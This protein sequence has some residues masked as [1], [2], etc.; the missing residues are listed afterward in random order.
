ML[1]LPVLLP[2][3]AFPDPLNVRHCVGVNCCRLPRTFMDSFNLFCSDL[4]LLGSL[5]LPLRFLS[6][7]IG[8]SFG[9]LSCAISRGRIGGFRFE[10]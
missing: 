1:G 5:G 3:H 4:S 6:G 9:N 8:L 7:V 10:A 2:Q